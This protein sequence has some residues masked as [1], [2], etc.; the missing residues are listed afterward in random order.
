MARMKVDQ[1]RT[2]LIAA[3]LRV[4]SG[5]G[6]SAATTRAVVAEADMSLA[7]FHYAFNSREEMM[8]EAIKTVINE[9]PG[10]VVDFV[11]A[12]TD[13]AAVL[14][15][16]LNAYLD[17]LI[18]DPGRQAAMVELNEY[19]I[20]VP[21]LKDLASLQYAA[22]RNSVQQTLSTT[23]E[24]F[25]WQWSVPLETMARLVLCIVDGVNLQWLAD[26][27][28]ASARATLQAAA[29]GLTVHVSQTAC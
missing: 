13:P 22:Y 7:S 5:R 25:G 26:R 10:L 16:A 1:R 20:R 29:R 2:G 3:A 4:M 23:S 28:T 21:A 12:S 18:A 19:A 15:Q 24:R 11:P 6:V 17:R 14:E 27:D 9:E 8:G